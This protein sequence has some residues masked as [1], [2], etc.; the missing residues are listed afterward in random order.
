LILAN[1][2]VDRTPGRSLLYPYLFLIASLLAIY[3]VPFDSFPFS[4][5]LLGVILAGAY[6]IPLFFAGIIFTESFRRFENKSTAF[7]SNIVGAVAGGLTQNLS[8]V[9]G[10]KALLLFAAILYACAGLFALSNLGQALAA[11]A[12]I[13]AVRTTRLTRL[14]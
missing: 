4:T 14:P 8:F 11:A 9:F 6:C 1:G 10:L 5:R 3:F 2:V 12:K 7:G 13:V